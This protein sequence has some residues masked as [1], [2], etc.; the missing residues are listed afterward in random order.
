MKGALSFSW[1]AIWRLVE[2]PLSLSFGKVIRVILEEN[3][4]IVETISEVSPFLRMTEEKGLRIA[5]GHPTCRG[6]ERG[7]PYVIA[8]EDLVTRILQIAA[9]KLMGKQRGLHQILE[10]TVVPAIPISLSLN[11]AQVDLT[12]SFQPFFALKDVVDPFFKVVKDQE[13]VFLSD[14]LLNILESR[15]A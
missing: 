5:A 2:T 6:D 11:P 3:L 15:G 9:V 1:G 13:P 4:N 12:V 7:R 14:C 10:L 8:V